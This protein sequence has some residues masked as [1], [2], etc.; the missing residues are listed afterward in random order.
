MGVVGYEV[1][2]GFNVLKRLIA[3][4]AQHIWITVQVEQS[5]GILRI[6]FA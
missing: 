5:F 3:G 1:I 2:S 6:E 4:I